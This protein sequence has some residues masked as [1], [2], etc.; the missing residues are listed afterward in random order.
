MRG[1]DISTILRIL[2]AVSRNSWVALS[3]CT[4]KCPLLITIPN[5]HVRGYDS[6]RAILPVAASH[7]AYLNP[8]TP[9]S[10]GRLP[11]SAK[12]FCRFKYMLVEKVA[13]E[14]SICIAIVAHIP[15]RYCC[16]ESQCSYAQWSEVENTYR[17]ILTPKDGTTGNSVG[18]TA[19]GIW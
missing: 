16:T 14:Y 5:L 19:C 18:L 8:S 15:G 1:F 9:S 7:G 4:V 11:S 13:I 10:A 2:Y 6:D 17:C 3:A 12:R